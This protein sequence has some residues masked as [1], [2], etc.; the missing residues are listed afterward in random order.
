[1]STVDQISI[2]RTSRRLWPLERVLFLMAGAMTILSAVLAALV[3]PWF[4]LLTVFVGAN[5]LAFVVFGDCPSSWLL[6]R[7]A[8]LERGCSR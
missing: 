7:Y 2:D 4:L 3:S 6:R 5:Q 8:G 1:M